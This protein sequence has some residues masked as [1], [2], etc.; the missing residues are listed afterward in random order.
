MVRCALCAVPYA[1]CAV[2]Y[3]LCAFSCLLC[4]VC[5]VLAQGAWCTEY[6]VWRCSSVRWARCW[7][8]LCFLFALSAPCAVCYSISSPSRQ[9]LLLCSASYGG[10][11]DAFTLVSLFFTGPLTP[12]GVVG[13]SVG[14]DDTVECSDIPCMLIA[15]F[16]AATLSL[17][18][19]GRGSGSVWPPMEADMMHISL[20]LPVLDTS[21]LWVLVLSAGNDDIVILQ[22]YH[23]L[24]YSGGANTP[25]RGR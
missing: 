15:P 23:P 22:R 20:S 4:A 1:L 2:H 6:C 25:P 24:S 9:G 16:L 12:L 19:L 14:Y 10:R 8:C 5:C 18:N 3:S 13:S 17:A 7:L 11:H 21:Y